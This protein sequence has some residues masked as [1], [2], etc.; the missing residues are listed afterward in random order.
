MIKTVAYNDFSNVSAEIRNDKNLLMKELLDFHAK[1][2]D[3]NLDIFKYEHH[4]AE[5][6]L[7]NEFKEPSYMIE[8]FEKGLLH[9]PNK[10]VLDIENKSIIQPLFYHEYWFRDNH[11]FYSDYFAQGITNLMEEIKSSGIDITEFS[12]QYKKYDGNIVKNDFEHPLL[13]LTVFREMVNI[14]MLEAILNHSPE[15]APL[16]KL[17]NRYSQENLPIYQTLLGPQMWDL[18]DKDLAIVL[19]KHNIAKDF[20]LKSDGALK[21]VIWKAVYNDDIDFIKNH[22][23]EWNLPLLEKIGGYDRPYLK[24]V[25]STEMANLLL[26]NGSYVEITE[27]GKESNIFSIQHFKNLIAIEAILDHPKYQH[28]ISQ[29]PEYFSHFFKNVSYGQE[30]KTEI[31]LTL[32]NKYNYDTDKIDLLYVGKELFSTYNKDGVEWALEHGADPRNCQEF[33]KQWVSKE[34]FSELKAIHTK[35]ILNLFY[36]DP[37]SEIIKHK[38]AQPA[39]NLIEKATSEDFGRETK[40]KKIAWWKVEGII[41]FKA[42]SKKIPNLN[43]LNSLGQSFL[44]YKSTIKDNI[45]NEFFNE[46]IKSHQVKNPNELL[47]IEGLDKNNNNILHNLFSPVLNGNKI[48]LLNYVLNL[49]E[50]YIRDLLIQENNNG[51]TPLEL[52]IIKITDEFS[53]NYN[54]P[55]YEYLVKSLK[56]VENDFDYNKTYEDKTLLEA[57]EKIIKLPEL[58]EEVRT[59][60]ALSH[61]NSIVPN[62]LDSKLKKKI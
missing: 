23:H 32:L 59:W 53:G 19:Y 62:K 16:W 52:A 6:W 25:Q 18:K 56:I 4:K 61:L 57:L 47:S 35:K 31:I 8:L 54:T 3:L 37:L 45:N 24:S 29:K 51:K 27:P 33:I 55:Y 21:D 58:M 43:V 20:I 40:Y 15:Y 11:N 42:I 60:A 26:E 44:Y 2:G 10:W 30:T 22:I 12:Y 9:S 36:P 13:T 1:G 34:N 46:V 48:P 14:K 5:E 28:L 39:F 41:N 17:P 49:N 38:L 50:E 7:R